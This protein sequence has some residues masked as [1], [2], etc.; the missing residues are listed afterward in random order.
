MRKDVLLLTLLYEF[1]FHVVQLTSLNLSLLQDTG[2]ISR[3]A[4]LRSATRPSWG[5]KALDCIFSKDNLYCNN[6]H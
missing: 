4:V 3:R 5:L 1:H 6:H 2:I